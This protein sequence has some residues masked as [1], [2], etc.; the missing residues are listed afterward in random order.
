[1]TACAECQDLSGAPAKTG[2]HAQLMRTKSIDL[3]SASHGRTTGTR[4]YYFCK[5]C[6][7]NLL[8]DEDEKDDDP[9]WGIA[10]EG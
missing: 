4:T 1:M 5:T 8:R 2:P 9:Q 3:G 10:K 7:S 6:G